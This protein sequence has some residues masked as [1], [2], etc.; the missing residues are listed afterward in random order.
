MSNDP[1]IEMDAWLA[2]FEQRKAELIAGG[3][4]QALADEVASAEIRRRIRSE[5]FRKPP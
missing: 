1:R 5:G 3:M 4:E 2:L